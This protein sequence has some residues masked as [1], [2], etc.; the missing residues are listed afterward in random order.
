[1]HSCKCQILI[2]R[3]DTF[4]LA[5]SVYE[6]RMQLNL[7]LPFNLWSTYSKMARMNSHT[8]RQKLFKKH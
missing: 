1:M 4:I 6:L 5:V 2:I 8:D 3:V 7:N